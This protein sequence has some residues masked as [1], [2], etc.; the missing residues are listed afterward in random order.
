MP[1]D[2]EELVLSLANA[3]RK[4]IEA[5]EKLEKE[6]KA[7]RAEH[8]VLKDILVGKGILLEGHR[9]NLGRI[10]DAAANRSARTVKLNVFV[11]KY[12]VK[13]TDV[14]CVALFSI[15]RARCCSFTHALSLQDVKEGIVKWDLENPYVIRHDADG[16]CTHQS[17]KTGGCTIHPHR[18]GTCRDYDCREDHRI[19]IDYEKRIPAPMPDGLV[20]HGD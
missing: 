2:T 10:G 5:R 1:M 13:N 17:R 20:P 12:T 14:D 18:P 4:E 3:V 9:T 15:C 8:D 16:Y 11:D 19:W 7:L 6:V